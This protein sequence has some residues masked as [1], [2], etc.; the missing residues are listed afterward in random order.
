MAVSKTDQE[1]VTERAKDRE[2]AAEAAQKMEEAG[3]NKSQPD[4]S[5]SQAEATTTTATSG[6]TVE[7]EVV[8]ALPMDHPAVDANPRR[9][10]PP[11]SSQIDFNDPTS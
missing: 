4:P 11:E 6:A 7:P 3:T 1:K 10:L 8:E 5:D 9:G 2:A